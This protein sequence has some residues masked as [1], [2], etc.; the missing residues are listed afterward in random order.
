M[1]IETV[2]LWIAYWPSQWQAATDNETIIDM[3]FGIFS[4]REIAIDKIKASIS[5]EE[6]E[7]FNDQFVFEKVELD[8]YHPIPHI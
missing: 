8:S 7:S 4:S 5:E 1:A 6:W 2:N 3:I